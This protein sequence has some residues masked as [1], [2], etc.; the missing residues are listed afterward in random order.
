MGRNMTR[1]ARLRWIDAQI[2]TGR[3]PSPEDVMAAFDVSR[4]TVFD[5]LRHLRDQIGAPI[6]HDR[7]RGGW[8]YSDPT[9]RLTALILTDAQT[10]TLHR[11]LLAAREHL[12]PGAQSGLDAFAA[13]LEQ[14]GLFGTAMISPQALHRCA[15][16]GRAVNFLD[17]AGRFK[18]RL[19]GPASGNVLLR[20]AQYEAHRDPARTLPLCQAIVA[21]KIRNAH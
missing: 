10:A 12:D 2:H 4:R 8:T 3:F 1:A 19:V 20:Q 21:G 6:V 14:N 7:A 18:C 15:E 13:W 16:D 9:F 5:D 17:H 11:A